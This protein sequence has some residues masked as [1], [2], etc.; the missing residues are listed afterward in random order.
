MDAVRPDALEEA[1]RRVLPPATFG[2]FRQGARD[3][4]SAAEAAD[5][6]ARFRIVPRV[7][8]DVRRVSL[9]TSV[10]GTDVPAPLGVAPCAARASIT[11]G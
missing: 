2:Y 5:A 11:A 9:A 4:L 6:W 7:L 8:R 3:G 1:A 10:L